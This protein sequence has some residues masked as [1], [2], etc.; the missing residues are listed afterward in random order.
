MIANWRWRCKTRGTLFLWA[1]SAIRLR[2]ACGSNR[3]HCSRRKPLPWGTLKL[4]WD[5]TAYAV[6]S[7]CGNYLSRA[8]AGRLRWK[9]R[10]LLEERSSKMTGAR[11][12][13]EGDASLRCRRLLTPRLPAPS[14]NRRVCC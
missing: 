10:A 14:S 12:E 1:R 3:C 13:S 2:G 8:L 11:C 6:A 7:R 9:W 5:P 4:L